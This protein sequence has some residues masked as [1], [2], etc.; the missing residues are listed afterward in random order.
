VSVIPTPFDESEGAKNPGDQRAIPLSNRPFLDPPLNARIWFK[1]AEFSIAANR[2]V[3]RVSG[4]VHDGSS[5]IS[6]RSLLTPGFQ[7][8]N[9][10]SQEWWSPISFGGLTMALPLQM[11]PVAGDRY[12]SS[13]VISFSRIE[14]VMPSANGA[15]TN[16]SCG[17]GTSCCPCGNAYACCGPNQACTC[18]GGSNPGC[19]SFL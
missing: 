10:V 15:C 6:A 2:F 12:S 5:G 3:V 13:A 19:K 17:P 11:R 4:C 1:K 16:N 14:G 8:L 18:I 9:A 7:S